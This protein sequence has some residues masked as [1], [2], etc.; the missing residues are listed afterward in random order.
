[1]PST[2]IGSDSYQF[3][4]VIGLTRAGSEPARFG[5]PDLPKWERGA[6]LIWPS[7]LV[8]ATASGVGDGV[9]VSEWVS[10]GVVKGLT[11][12][13]WVVQ[14]QGASLPSVLT[15]TVTLP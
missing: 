7:C 10:V 14:L 13:P 8:S 6:L 5:F 12:L 9:G 11:V 2:W 1:M 15:D 3:F 4:Q